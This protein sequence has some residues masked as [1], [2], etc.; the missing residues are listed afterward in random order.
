HIAV[1][2]VKTSNAAAGS[3]A[4][5]VETRTRGVISSTAPP[6]TCSARGGTRPFRIRLEGVELPRPEP[7][8]FSP[9]A[10]QPGQPRG[11]QT[12]N[13]PP[14]VVFDRGGLDEA[15]PVE[16][17]QMPARRRRAHAQS[18]GNVA[19]A[20]RFA[21]QQLDDAA[22]CRVGERGKGPVDFG[23]RRRTGRHL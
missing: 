22:P 12:K 9:P 13:T 21:S 20:L 4:T 3:V 19:G 6:A 7:F 8:H 17:A 14:R 2:R 10:R 5:I 18:R 11:A 1:S 23:A 16:Q 15:R